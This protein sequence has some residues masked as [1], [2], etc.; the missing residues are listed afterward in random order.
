M[1]KDGV[2]EKRAL[3]RQQ[4]LLWVAGAIV[5]AAGQVAMGFGNGPH[6]DVAGQG[7]NNYLVWVNQDNDGRVGEIVSTY[8]SQ[9]VAGS[10]EEDGDLRQRNHFWDP[11]TG[12]G[13]WLGIPALEYAEELYADALSA[14]ETERYSEGFGTGAYNYLGRVIHLIGDMSVPAHVLIDEHINGDTYE[15]YMGTAAHYE[16]IPATGI[17]TGTLEQLMRYVA[18][19]ADDYDS[20]DIRGET[21]LV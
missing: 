13:Y 16:N 19:I 8:S 15:T 21:S 10:V 1:K 14:Y 4:R 9:I 3:C 17:E 11:D 6:G 20:D 5:C 12:T 7:I 18:E 2:Q